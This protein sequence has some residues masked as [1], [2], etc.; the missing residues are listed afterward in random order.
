M[1]IPSDIMRIM[2]ESNY[3][4]AYQSLNKEQKRAVDTIDGPVMVVAGPGTGKTQVL[5]MRIANILMNTG[6]PDEVLCLTFTNSG[7][8]AMR[9]RLLRIIGQVA[10]KITVETF[11]S[12]AIRI[13]E[14][15]H[16][17]LPDGKMPILL[18]EA[19][20]VL[21]CDK[22]FEEYDWEHLRTRG[23]TTLYF[24]D[25]KSLISLLKRES[26]TPE[27]FKIEIENEIK[28]IKLD[29]NSL[30]SRGET[31]GQIKKEI[32][33][34][35]E[36]LERTLE[37]VKFYEIYEQKKK[38]KSLYD[39][40][41]VL[42]SL[43]YL[44][45]A[46]EDV[47]SDIREDYQYVLVDEHQDSSGIQNNFL[48]SVWADI[49]KPNIFVV[50][51]D[52]QLIYGFGGASIEYFKDFTE[53][54][55]GTEVI[56]LKDNYR[57]TQTILDTAGGIIQSSITN[58]KLSS[59]SGQGEKIHLYEC[60]YPRDEILRLAVDLKDKIEKENLDINK[61]ALLVPKNKQVRSAIEILST[62]GLPVASG[63]S[64]NLLSTKEAISFMN[65]LSA[66]YAPNPE[67]LSKTL[68][69]PVNKISPLI[70]HKFIREV[71][72]NNI[73]LE[74]LV[75]ISGDKLFNEY[76]SVKAWG[77]NL[78]EY[79][80][81]FSTHTFP[82]A[83][84]IVGNKLFVT[85]SQSHEDL[86]RAVEVVRTFLHLALLQYENNP[87]I[88][89]KEFIEFI[90]RLYS[91][92]EHIPLATFGKANGINIMT[93]HGSKG[94][95]FDY[96]WIAHMDEKSLSGKRSSSFSLPESVEQKIETRS[97]EVQKRELYVAIT[98]A[99]NHCA[100]SYAVT[101][102]SGAS[103]TASKIIEDIGRDTFIFENKEESESKIVGSDI[104]NYLVAD[105]TNEDNTTITDLGNMVA[106]EYEKKKISVTLLNNFFECPWRWYF[107]NFL[108]LPE[109][110][111]PHLAFGSV[112]HESIE[113]ILKSGKKPT[114]KDLEI[115]IADSLSRND[116][117]D[118]N[119]I[120]RM[121]ADGIKTLSSWVTKCL[122]KIEKNYESEKDISCK[123]SEVPSLT[124]YGKIDLLERN[125][126]GDI[127]ITDFKT[128]K[129]KS[130]N[131][132]EKVDE[133]GR[134]NSYMRQLAMYSLLMKNGEKKEVKQSTLQFIE[135]IE[136]SKDA[137]YTT[138][139]SDEEI[140]MLKKDIIDYDNMLKSGSWVNMP[141]NWKPYG[142]GVDKCPYCELSKQ[143]FQF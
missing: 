5:A 74:S 126:S 54:F 43:V 129:A 30:S 2:Q 79:I 42:T 31:K 38:E 14:K 45:S 128:G 131:T 134:M 35:I 73:T 101:S 94:L 114:K 19:E 113:S 136:T 86:V 133:S 68:L 50:G 108:G 91:Y 6:K 18:D 117:I 109:G 70:T 15:Y 20:A 55:N 36:S 141:C 78:L 139:V 11:H 26:L 95:E 58:V 69:D 63:D 92:G 29:P 4:E 67:N 121:K 72:A 137:I 81:I 115:Y 123:I 140:D 130:K 87:R 62:L 120:R 37:V 34:R 77:D 132:I 32:L 48:K 10:S 135:D 16:E 143:V 97:E 119:E 99:R 40:D 7:A 100:I 102:Y 27:D 127:Y 111:N 60:E 39:Y 76:D 49:V 56:T 23:D 89:L 83:V 82:S 80:N 142:S 25:I 17:L 103:L 122:P 12:F 61:C 46:F 124:F 52:R 88:T 13:L 47:R 65:V 21:L 41:D 125:K 8:R 28:N 116:V 138:T 1:D 33:K 59:Q 22:I 104:R 107:K 51:D 66:I 71:R 44:V 57:S 64:L 105:E 110:K 96:V 53:T 9:A 112:M 84:Q 75:A 3:K 24:R 98:R 90:N 93:L 118:S 106:K 85:N